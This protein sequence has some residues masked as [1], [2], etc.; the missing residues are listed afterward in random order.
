M[1]AIKRSSSILALSLGLLILVSFGATAY[2]CSPRPGFVREQLEG[3]SLFIT[4]SSLGPTYTNKHEYL[5]IFSRGDGAS[6]GP[7]V[8]H[9]KIIPA[10]AMLSLL[11]FLIGGIVLVIKKRSVP[12]R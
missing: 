11:V 9:I 7:Y 6:C 1:Q 10:V 2:G 5:P 12:M 8:T 4:T 3:T